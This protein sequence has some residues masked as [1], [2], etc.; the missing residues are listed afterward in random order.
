M[1]LQGGKEL[2]T[3]RIQLRYKGGQSNQAE[4]K[5]LRDLEMQ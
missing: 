2:E 1:E 3:M 4:R 5:G